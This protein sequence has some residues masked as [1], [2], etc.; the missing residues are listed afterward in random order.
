MARRRLPSE[1]VPHLRATLLQLA[2]RLSEVGAGDGEELQVDLVVDSTRAATV[3][4]GVA[5][6]DRNVRLVLGALASGGRLPTSAV[7][8][9]AGYK[10]GSYRQRTTIRTTDE[11]GAPIEIER[12]RT[13]S[14]R[15]ILAAAVLIVS[16]STGIGIVG[17]WVPPELI[18][19]VLHELAPELEQA[20]RGTQ[21]ELPGS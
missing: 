1:S 20:P 10:G 6:F 7:H 4:Q 21:I 11:S 8:L 12:E 3:T 14:T 9:Q 2:A 19:E 16:A 5:S 18:P 15:F 13:I 17:G